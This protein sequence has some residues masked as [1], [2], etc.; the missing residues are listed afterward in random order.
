MIFDS[1]RLQL[2]ESRHLAQESVRSQRYQRQL[3]SRTRPF[4][5]LL[6]P[7]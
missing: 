2:P 3:L 7:S 1:C 5:V 4:R 6:R